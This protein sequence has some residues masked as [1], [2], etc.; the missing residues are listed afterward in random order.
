MTKGPEGSTPL[1]GRYANCFSIGHNALEFVLD[2]GQFYPGAEKQQMH[3]RIVT[4]PSYARALLD[5]L[6][7]AIAEYE[8]S[9]GAI[10]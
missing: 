8:R 6:Q 4:N 10:D 5:T 1:E 7:R 2:F 3:T 9:F